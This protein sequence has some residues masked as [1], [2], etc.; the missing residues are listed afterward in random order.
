MSAPLRA[1]ALDYPLDPAAIALRPAEPRD[2]A[3]LLVVHLAEDR[4]EHRRVRDLPEYLA[5]GDAIVVNRTTVEPRRLRLRRSGGGRAEGLLIEPLGDDR[6]RALLKPSARLR[7]GDRLEVIAAQAGGGGTLHLEGRDAEAWRVRLEGGASERADLAASAWTPLPP[8]IL[9]ARR[10]AGIADAEAEAE[11]ERLDRE[12][13]QTI[14]ARGDWRPSVAAPTAGL[15]F[16]PSLLDRLAAIPVERIEVELSV[17]AGTFRGVD[18]E[19]LAEHRMESEWCRV[20]AEPLEAL[21]RLDRRRCEGAGRVLAVGSTSVRVLE[22]LPQPLPE[23]SGPLEFPTDLLIA[24]GYAFRRLDLLLTNFHLPRSTLI[25][26]VAA[27]VGLDR[28][29]EIYALALREGYRFYSY[30]DAMLVIR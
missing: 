24:P 16:T 3:R 11:E 29:K 6:W 8:Y 26:L 9:K 14:Y 21:R 12:R 13:Y 28:L 4:I 1:E 23:A 22:S 2:A 7:V 27:V 18:T 30:G 15:H 25:A 5:A 20:E 17:G 10:D 19:T